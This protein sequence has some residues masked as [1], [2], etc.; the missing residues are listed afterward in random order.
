LASL[1]GRPGL[2]MARSVHVCDDPDDLTLT[3]AKLG[4]KY[5]LL[6]IHVTDQIVN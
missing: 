1:G 2:G 3:P 6:M 4:Q 5:P